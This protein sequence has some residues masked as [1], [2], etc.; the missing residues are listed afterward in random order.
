MRALAVSRGQGKS[1]TRVVS[2]GMADVTKVTISDYVKI[3]L[4]F[5]TNADV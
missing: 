1:V 2:R 4:K 3:Q 5:G